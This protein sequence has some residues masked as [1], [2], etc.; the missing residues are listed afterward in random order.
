MSHT[1]ANISCLVSKS[2]QSTVNFYTILTQFTLNVIAVA[3]T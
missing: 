2:C 1:E 3:L